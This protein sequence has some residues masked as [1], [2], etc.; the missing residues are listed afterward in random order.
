[1]PLFYV[2]ICAWGERG[3]TKAAGHVY[4]MTSVAS[5]PTQKLSRRVFVPFVSSLI[6]IHFLRLQE[7]TRN[8]LKNARVERNEF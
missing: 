1:M 8:V 3:G 6:N 2:H 4:K 5:S 7:G